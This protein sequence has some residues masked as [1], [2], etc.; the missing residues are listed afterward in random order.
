[1]ANDEEWIQDV[2]RWYR[3]GSTLMSS[4]PGDSG[5]DEVAIGYEAA[6]PALQARYWPDPA[7]TTDR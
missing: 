4:E 1:M 7:S 5:D 6:H 3:A 2:K